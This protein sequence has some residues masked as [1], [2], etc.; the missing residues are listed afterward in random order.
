MKKPILFLICL[1]LCVCTVASAAP[2]FTYEESTPIAKSI[3]FSRVQAFYGDHNLSYSVIKADLSDEN[4]ALRLLKSKKGTDEMETVGQLAGTEENVVAAQN[5]DF[6]SAH[7]GTKGFSLGLEVQDGKLLQSP[8]SPQEMATIS[9]QDGI[10][11]MSYLD[12]HIMVVAPNWA[13]H[14][15]RHLNK[16]TS[17]YGDILMYTADFNDGYSPAP[18]GEVVEVV[19]SGGVV[20]E[21]RR[22]QGPVKIPEDGCVLVVSEGMNMFLANNF[23][24]GDAIHF[25]Y[26]VTPDILGAEAALGGGAMLLSEGKIP[27]TFSHVI[28]GENPRSAIGID[29]EGKTLY[30]VAVDG[31][32][33]MSR[34]MRMRELALLMQSLGCYT[35]VNLDGGGSTNMVA[36]TVWEEELHTVNAP[37]ENRRVINAVGLTYSAPATAPCGI[38]LR[39]DKDTVFLGEPIRISA[40]AYDENER[41]VEGE[42]QLSSA[43]GEIEG[44]IFTPTKGGRVTVEA[45]L[46]EVEAQMELYAVDTVSGIQTTPY[47]HL[48]KGETASLSLSV[49]DALGHS[50]SVSRTENFKITSTNPSVATVSGQTVTA[51]GEG[52][53][54]IAVRKDGAVSYT[55]VAVGTKSEQ[56]VESFEFPAGTFSAYPAEVGGACEGSDARAALG[57][58]SAKLSFDFTKGEADGK[59]AHFLLLEQPILSPGEDSISVRFYTEEEFSHS[60]W[61]QFTCGGEILTYPFVGEYTA[62]GWQTLT[63]TLPAS[64]PRPLQLDSLYVRGEGGEPCDS[65]AVYLDALTYFVDVTAVPEAAPPNVYTVPMEEGKA[66]FVISTCPADNTLLG[67]LVRQKTKEA[68]SDAAKSLQLEDIDSFL[69]QEDNGTLYI[70]VNTAAGGIRKTDAGQWDKLKAAVDETKAERIF[71]LAGHPI[72]GK[73]DFENRVIRDFLGTLPQEVFVITRG[74]RNTCQNIDGVWYFTIG[75]EGTALSAD[76]I[77][78]YRYLQ[79]SFGDKTDFTFK[80]VCK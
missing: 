27:E 35:A 48:K 18:G 41:P 58:R 66:D 1:L 67:S 13:Y 52:T 22:G 37:T 40:A 24:V 76:H 51:E 39:S 12:F 15:I 16:H 23:A 43:F 72:F 7:R 44:D 14:E 4:T 80:P 57:A 75:N 2:I 29:K 50:V 60:L 54:I 59:S 31:R 33:T 9:Y 64:A 61:A 3:E 8:I 73:D 74:A 62:G 28:A 53:A 49:F 70:T 68:A 21:F 11:A 45:S 17:Y 56:V 25:D 32:Q 47:I 69:A 78:N 79:F 10:A 55:S 71:L 38:L 30:L 19:V 77:G 20:T 63:L 46:G 36:S 26:Y 42:I 65:G 6:F 34:G 5:A